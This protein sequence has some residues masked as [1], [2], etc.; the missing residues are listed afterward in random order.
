MS[1]DDTAAY[2]ADVHRAFKF[3]TKM[4]GKRQEALDL[5]AEFDELFESTFPSGTESSEVVDAPSSS[6][7]RPREVEEDSKT[8]KRAAVEGETQKVSYS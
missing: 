7:K 5:Q 6:T 3:A 4:R 1:T 2:Q 8:K